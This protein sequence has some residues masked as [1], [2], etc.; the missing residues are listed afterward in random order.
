MGS[1][2]LLLDF[3]SSLKL[4]FVPS[5]LGSQHGAIYIL[6]SPRI[7]SLVPFSNFNK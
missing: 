7:S 1:T 5:N 3:S 4:D 2:V 6:C